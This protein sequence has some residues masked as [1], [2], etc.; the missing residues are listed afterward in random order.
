MN[1]GYDFLDIFLTF[2]WNMF[3]TEQVKWFAH[4]FER[5]ANTDG[6]ACKTD[7]LDV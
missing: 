2:A 1:Y 3:D 4:V 7:L 6:V 5:T